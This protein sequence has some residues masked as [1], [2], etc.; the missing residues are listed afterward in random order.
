MRPQVEAD[1]VEVLRGSLLDFLIR[2]R[3]GTY[4]IWVCNGGREND[5]LEDSVVREI[6]TNKLRPTIRR[7]HIHPRGR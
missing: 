1:V 2:E 6:D 5:G 7:Q 4:A 3:E